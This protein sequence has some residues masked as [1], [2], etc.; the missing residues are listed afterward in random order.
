MMATHGCI[1]S[2]HDEHTLLWSL[3]CVACLIYLS[4]GCF[5]E[6]FLTA[7]VPAGV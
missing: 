2:M 6:T 3:M 7:H 5:L 4:A 1:A